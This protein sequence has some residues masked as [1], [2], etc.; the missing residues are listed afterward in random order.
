M[1]DDKNLSKSD[2]QGLTTR[3]GVVAFFAELG[4]GT[5]SRQPRVFRQWGLLPRRWCT[6][7]NISSVL[8]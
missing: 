2:V 6:R 8:L 1:T 4:Y 7:S 3:D 5:D